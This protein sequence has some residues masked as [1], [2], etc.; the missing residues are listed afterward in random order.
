MDHDRISL[1]MVQD[2]PLDIN[3]SCFS[4]KDGFNLH[5]AA[6]IDEACGMIKSL[7]PELVLVSPATLNPESMLQALQSMTSSCS[8]VK[9][10]F[11]IGVDEFPGPED[12]VRLLQGGFDGFFIKPLVAEEVK[13][14]FQIHREKRLLEQK[15][16]SLESKLEKAF[17][18]LDS[19]KKELK[20]TKSDLYEERITLN[21]TLKQVNQMTRERSRLKKKEK[22]LKLSLKRNIDGFSDMFIDLIKLQ[23]EDNRG[24]SER[25]AH[26][27]A[28][29]GRQLKLSEK[30][31]EDLRKAAMLH[32]I[33]C[34]FV[35]WEILS[36]QEDQLQDWEKD[37]LMQNPAK[38]SQLLLSCSEFENCARIIQ[39]INENSDGTGRPQ[40]LKRRYIPLAS[41]VLAG[42]D[43]FD[44]LKDDTAVTDLQDFLSRLEGLSGSRLDPNIVAQLEKYAV[45]HMGSDTYKVKGL[46][47]HQ[48]E[49]GMIL[50]TAIFTN[51]GTKLFSVNT[52]LTR[53][54]IDKIRKYNR[55][56]PVDETV[57]IKA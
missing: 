46:G 45:L 27:A 20:S 14:T 38:G 9:P 34:L 22:D 13:E 49:P 24:H 40:G 47:I 23:V 16:V 57:Y 35:P 54:A 39:S 48:L 18:Y 29:V 36:K 1:L 28:F 17:R 3:P 53:D 42:A 41:K 51:T 55:E 5:T 32:E 2:G 50:G 4:K 30:S 37:L 7:S 43:E 6:G 21:N 19:F 25:V 10:V 12:R 52:L 33:G 44:M 26:I 15:N 8:A 56:Y 31:L 11:F